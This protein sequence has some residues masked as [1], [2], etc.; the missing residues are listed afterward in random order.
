MHLKPWL[1]VLITVCN[2]CVWPPHLS[3]TSVLRF[4]VDDQIRIVRRS[5]II[6]KIAA[7]VTS[8][9]H[10]HAPHVANC[11]VDKISQ[12]WRKDRVCWVGT[13][14]FEELKVFRTQARDSSFGNIHPEID[15]RQDPHYFSLRIALELFVIGN[16]GRNSRQQ[17]L[18]HGLL[19]ML[20]E[21]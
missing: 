11:A 5:L 16:R 17:N 4:S 20:Q 7:P 12:A 18:S 19:P 15:E 10:C 13:S 8:R 1:Y 6:W 3:K 2:P 9:R 14:A 21:R